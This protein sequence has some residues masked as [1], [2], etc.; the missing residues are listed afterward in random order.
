MTGVKVLVVGQND[1]TLNAISLGFGLR[2]AD[3]EIRSADTSREAIEL[4]ETEA[5]HLVI[6]EIELPHG[7]GFDLIRTVRLFSD[8][9]IIVLSHVADELEIVKALELGADDYVVKP[10][11]ALGFLARARAVLRRS[12]TYPHRAEDLPPF[13]CDR[14]VLDFAAKQ[15]YVDGEPVHLTPTEYA[16]LHQLVRNAGRLV[17]LDTLRRFVG[18][19]GDGLKSSTIRKS[20]SQLRYKLGNRDS[21]NMILNE[22]GIGYRFLWHAD[23]S[24]RTGTNNRQT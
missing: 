16:I 12:A 19:D 21:A 1:Q 2:W 11:S 6:T 24:V 22:R 5:P 10:P 9:P 4:V 14:M 20:V 17:T 15:V 18:P 23:Q 7:S 3:C 8:V 13:V